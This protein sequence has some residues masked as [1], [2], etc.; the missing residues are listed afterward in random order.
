[1][2]VGF[3]LIGLS[4]KGNKAIK[5]YEK[6]DKKAYVKRISDNPLIISFVFY[7]RFR[8]FITSE[9]IKSFTGLT[10]KGKDCFIDVDY[11]IEV[12]E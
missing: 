9:S 5:I 8:R 11:K 10:M 6:S 2:V 1:M 12:I 3:K 7:E 4:E